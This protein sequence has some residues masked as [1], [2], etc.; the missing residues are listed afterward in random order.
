LAAEIF[1][2]TYLMIYKESFLPKCTSFYQ[3]TYVIYI[4]NDYK[5]LSTTFFNHSYDIVLKL[6]Q[7]PEPSWVWCRHEI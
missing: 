4:S 3:Q 6:Y 7:R 2:N 5:V 1:V